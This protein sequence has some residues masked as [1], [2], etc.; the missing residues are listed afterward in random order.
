L[1][2]KVD[3]DRVPVRPFGVVPDPEAFKELA[4]QDR[5]FVFRCVL[6]WEAK[7]SGQGRS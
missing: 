6:K 4:K 2:S 5:P 7:H 3:L 1:Q